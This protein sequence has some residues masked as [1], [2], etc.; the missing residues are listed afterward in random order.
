LT[1]T[2]DWPHYGIL[3]ADKSTKKAKPNKINLRFRDARRLKKVRE[4]AVIEDVSINRFIE[5][6]AIKA[7]EN[8]IA[9]KEQGTL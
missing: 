1:G 7:A 9:A 2:L 6:A 8:V 4:A 5:R 3:M